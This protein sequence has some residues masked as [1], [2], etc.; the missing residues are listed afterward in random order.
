[1]EKKGLNH[2]NSSVNSFLRENINHKLSSRSTQQ[3]QWRN[4]RYS[5]IRHQKKDCLEKKAGKNKYSSNRDLAARRSGRD[6]DD[7]RRLH[8]SKKSN[9]RL[10]N[11]WCP[12]DCENFPLGIIENW[13]SCMYL[14]S[15]IFIKNN[16]IKYFYILLKRSQV[17]IMDLK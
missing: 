11:K 10:G 2:Q 4:F 3:M 14:I 15:I 9:K 16:E 7:I 5:G 13:R 8:R 12:L 6:P 17:G 1:M